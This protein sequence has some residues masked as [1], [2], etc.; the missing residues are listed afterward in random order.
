MEIVDVTH[1]KGEGGEGA[2]KFLWLE[3][4]AAK[5]NSITTTATND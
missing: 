2:L 1:S 3:S 5:E 4:V